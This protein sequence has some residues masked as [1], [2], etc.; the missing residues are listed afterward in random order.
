[1]G[2]LAEH[3]EWLV[4]GFLLAIFWALSQTFARKE[5]L[6]DHEALVMGLVRDLESRPKQAEMH[7]LQVQIVKV[8]GKLDVIEHQHNLLVEGLMREA[9]GGGQS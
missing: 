6:R 5:K 8:Q 2:F 9:Q 7:D 4:N 1:M 3:V